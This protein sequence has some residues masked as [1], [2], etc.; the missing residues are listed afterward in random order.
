MGPLFWSR[1]GDVACA[2][3]VPDASSP[4]RIAEQ[5]TAIDATALERG[6]YRC[7]RC[8]SRPLKRTTRVTAETLGAVV[9][10]D[11]A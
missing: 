5:W 7:Q 1:N 4:R 3:H 2:D 11:V 6:T 8:A 9:R 10:H